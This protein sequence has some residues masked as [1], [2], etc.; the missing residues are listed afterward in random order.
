MASNFIQAG[1]TV[2]VALPYTRTSGQAAKIG[3]LFGVC[4]KGGTATDPD[5]LHVEGVFDITTLTTDTPAVGA[6]MYWDDGNRR[7]TTTAS[8]HL[9]VAIALVAKLTGATTTRVKL[10]PTAT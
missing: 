10:V 4:A 1:A 2:P 3:Q 7:L 9:P 8:T 6:T 5:E